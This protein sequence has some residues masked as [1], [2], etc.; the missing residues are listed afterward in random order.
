M[1]TVELRFGALPAHVRTARLV[2][3]AVARRSG[4]DDGLI[5]EVK[6][7][8][9]EA[10]ARALGLHEAHAPLEQVV[11]ELLEGADEF[12]VVVHDSGPADASVQIPAARTEDLPALLESSLGADDGA[13][14]SAPLQLALIAGLVDELTVDR[15]GDRTAVRMRWSLKNVARA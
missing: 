5:D 4:V 8:V 12:V 11:I 9:G 3:A 7:A 6:L 2:A 14:S 1:A 13:T 10:C 15:N